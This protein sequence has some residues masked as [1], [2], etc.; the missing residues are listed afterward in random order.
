LP[1]N[2]TERNLV[3]D[4]KRKPMTDLSKLSHAELMAKNAREKKAIEEAP[5]RLSRLMARE[6]AKE[7][8]KEWLKRNG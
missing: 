2:Q 6:S 3:T 8:L 7:T 1:T 4:E 5:D